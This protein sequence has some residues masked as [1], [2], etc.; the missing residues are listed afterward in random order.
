MKKTLAVILHYNS[1]QFTD[2]LYRQ[3]K[4]F[5][6]NCY[7]LIVVDNGSEPTRVS[8]YATFSLDKN[9]YFGGG[10]NA[11]FDYFLDQTQYDSLLFLNSD[12]IV[13]GYNFVKTLRKILFNNNLYILSPSIIQPFENQC[14]WK[15]MH[16]WNSE[17]VRIVKW[18]DF[19]APLFRREFVE[20]IKKFD[21]ELIFGWGQDVLSGIICEQ[22]NWVIGVSDLVPA[23]HLDSQTMKDNNMIQSYRNNA[24]KGMINFFD[25]QNLLSKLQEFRNYGQ[26]YKYEGH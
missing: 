25:K 23:V 19:Q 21:D 3:L 11:T 16:N 2:V 15:Q 10:L 5:E 24:E 9:Y 1:T 18:I 7:E 8:Q 6:G 22:M 20:H 17:T 13:N 4:P 12:L 14:F 26:Y